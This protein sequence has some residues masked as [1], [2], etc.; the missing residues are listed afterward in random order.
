[1]ALCDRMEVALTTTDATRAR[2]LEAVLHEALQPEAEL[3][4]AAE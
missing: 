3:V 2:L 1:M 4:E